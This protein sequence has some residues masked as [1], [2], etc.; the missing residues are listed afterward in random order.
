M[1]KRCFKNLSGNYFIFQGEYK[2]LDG[3]HRLA[4]LCNLVRSGDV[5]PDILV[6]CWVISPFGHT[7][8]EVDL[9]VKT[10]EDLRTRVELYRV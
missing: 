10:G 3:C 4:A 7:H 8:E 5:Q 9:S 1:S 2:V 6:P